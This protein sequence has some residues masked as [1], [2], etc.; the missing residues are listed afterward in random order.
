VGASVAAP[1]EQFT[2]IR[3]RDAR[4][5]VKS[6]LERVSLA[7]SLVDQYPDQ[8]SGGERQRV[9]IARSLICEPRVLICDEITS[10][11]DVS[12]QASIVA[13]LQRLREEDQL[14]LLFVTHDLPLVRSI[15]DRV[16]VLNR[17]RIVEC[18]AADQVLESPHDTYTKSLI[19]DTPDPVAL[20]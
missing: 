1:L 13:L 16:A 2:G 14:S 15:A 3:G 20:A 4:E 9:A 12:V 8:L 18:G 17:G 10:A 19:A 11:L 6:A 5:R 7:G